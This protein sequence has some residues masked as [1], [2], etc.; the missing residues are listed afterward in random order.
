MLLSLVLYA[1]IY[2]WP[3]AAG[4]IGLLFCHE[5]GHYF[6]ARQRG[7]AVGLPM[8][9]PFVGAAIFMKENPPDAE[10]EA[11]VAFAGPFVGA[12]CSF[13][14]Y[15]IWGDSRLGLA[16]AYS[17]FL[18]NFINLIP[19]SPLDG[20][21][22]TA[23]LS[24]RIWLLGLPLLGALL[25]YQPSPALLLVLILALPRLVQA[26]RF[27]PKAPE[28]LAYYTAVPFSIRLEYALMYFGLT[29]VLG[30]VSFGVHE[31]LQGGS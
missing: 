14:V 30:L 8:F 24:P 23:V 31:R 9:I 20:G 28:Y 11:Y 19:I 18:L 27:D 16:I 6:A 5:M 25:L 17:G 4:F 1:Q 15:L 10:V 13:L 7:L 12:V 21:R 22:I 3:F 2:G 26:W 29:A